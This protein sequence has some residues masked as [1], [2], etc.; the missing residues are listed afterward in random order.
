MPTRIVDLTLTLTH[1]LR[2][3][4]TKPPFTLIPYTRAAT[5][6]L[7]FNTNLVVMEDHTGT[8]VDASLHFYDGETRTPRGRSIADL[9]LEKLYGDAVCI[10]VSEKSPADP[11]D[12]TML[13]RAVAVGDIELRRDDIVLVRFWPGAW[14]E[15]REKFFASRGLAL[16]ACKWLVERGAK[17]VGV[18]HPNLEGRVEPTGGEYEYPGHLL[19]LHPEREIP[20]VENLVNLD[21]LSGRRFRFF[22]L[23]LKMDGATGSP[24]RAIALVES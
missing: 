2:T 4:D 7:G 16:D 10:D 19:L 24:V 13:R 8:H 3:W 22:A 21:R 15:P 18:D 17:C 5:S 1:G 9:P 14:G 11:V 23:P 12:A 6:R 20:I